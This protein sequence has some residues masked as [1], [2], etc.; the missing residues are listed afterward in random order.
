MPIRKCPNC[1]MPKLSNAQSCTQ[2]PIY[3]NAHTQM[4][5]CKCPYANAHMQMPKLSN[6]QIVK[7]P[8]CQMPKAVRKCPYANAHTQMP[9]CKCPYANANAHMQMPICKSPYSCMQMPICKCPTPFACENGYLKMYS[10]KWV[11]PYCRTLVLKYLSTTSRPS[12]VHRNLLLGKA[13]SC[14]T[15]PSTSTCT[16][17]LRVLHVV[18]AVPTTTSPTGSS[19]TVPVVYGTSTSTV[20]TAVL[21]VVLVVDLLVGLLGLVELL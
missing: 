9:I 8:N 18:H 4:P 7:C 19:T 20:A 21:L 11:R 1:Q 2:M 12:T 5:I 14:T 15:S 6:A 3:A 10:C 17:V 13:Y 16:A